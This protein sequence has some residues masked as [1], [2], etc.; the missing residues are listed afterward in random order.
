MTPEERIRIRTELLQV[1]LTDCR[2]QGLFRACILLADLEMLLALATG[3]TP[4]VIVD[5]TLPPGTA[6]LQTERQAVVIRN[7]GEAEAP[8]IT[9]DVVKRTW[10]KVVRHLSTMNYPT[11]VLI[12]GSVVDLVGHNAIVKVPIPPS[13]NNPIRAEAEGMLN[14]ALHT[15][16]YG[17]RFVRDEY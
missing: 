4:T 1:K 15:T 2:A 10:E 7:I 9:L 6:V 8:E 17:I 13:M 3:T 14:Q 16:G 11:N 12:D 5:E